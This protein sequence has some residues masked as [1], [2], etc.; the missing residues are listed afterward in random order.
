MTKF[1]DFDKKAGDVLGD[2]VYKYDTNLKIKTKASGAKLSVSGDQKSQKFTAEYSPFDG[3]NISKFSVGTNNKI[4]ADATMDKVMDGLKFAVNY[5]GNTSG[6]TK[7]A[8]IKVDYKGAGFVSN[9]KISP[10]KSVVTESLSVNYES[11]W[12]GGSGTFNNGGLSKYDVGL[13]YSESDFSA[14]LKAAPGKS[15]DWDLSTSYFQQVDADTSVA[16]KINMAA[17]G[18]DARSTDLTIGATHKLDAT[19]TVSSKIGFDGAKTGELPLAFA[20]DTKLNDTIG[21]VAGA[22]VNALNFGAD[23]GKF[24]VNLTVNV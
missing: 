5:E 11:F 7:K 8:D 23:S 17:F 21:M 15:G 9:T 14:S 18:S 2:D 6:E 20:Y 22:E 19:N 10:L 4:V 13:L 1:G 24:G 16:A 12:F 3:F